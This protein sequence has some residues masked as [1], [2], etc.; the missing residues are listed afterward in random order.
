MSKYEM[1]E[2]SFKLFKNKKT[3][4]TQPD[5]KG[6]IKINGEEFELSA[7]INESKSGVK[8][9]AGNFSRPRVQTPEQGDTVMFGGD[10][11]QDE[12]PF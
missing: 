2:G 7:W 3:K 1:R 5:Y 10:A 8:Y 6:M 4:E 9:M 11:P 12:V